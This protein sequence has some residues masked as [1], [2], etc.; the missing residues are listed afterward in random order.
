FKWTLISILVLISLPILLI[1]FIL[2]GMGIIAI[3]D[4]YKEKN[5]PSQSITEKVYS[6]GRKTLRSFGARKQF[7]II[8][9]SLDKNEQTTFKKARLSLYD[10][11]NSKS[12]ERNI[13]KYKEISP[14]LY[15]IGNKK[16]YTKLNY[17]TGEVIQS[18]NIDDFSEEDKEIFKA[19]D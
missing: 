11:D 17:D 13:E 2:F 14:C 10:R 16:G 4:K 18:K 8:R 12:L 1:Y 15:V 7:A 9:F 3:H 6:D 5:Q 19:F